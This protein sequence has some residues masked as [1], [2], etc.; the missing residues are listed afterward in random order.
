MPRLMPPTLLMC[1][2]NRRPTAATVSSAKMTRWE[3]VAEVC[4]EAKQSML[5]DLCCTYV[6]IS[7]YHSPR[8]AD[9]ASSDDET[10]PPS[11]P[12]EP[13]CANPILEAKANREPSPRGEPEP[14]RVQNGENVSSVPVVNQAQTRRG[15]GPAKCIEFEK[16]RKHGKV[17]LK[18]NNGETTLCCEN[19]SMF[20][21]RVSWIVKHY[22]NMS[23][24]RWSDVPQAHK[25]EL[26][27]RVR[28]THWSKKNDKFV[29]PTTED[30]YD[31]VGKLDTLEPEKQTDEIATGV[32]KEVLGHRPGYARGLGE[33]VIPEST[34]QRF[35]GTRERV[36]SFD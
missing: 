16:L 27:D 14:D 21:T 30:V 17:F 5:E 23:Y 19:A 7:S 24:L 9:Q 15:R 32:F 20:I 18:I 26:I 2:F 4:P 1:R 13:P 31:M 22:C 36:H 8:E 12:W 34:R 11:H 28:E 29:T 10:Q 6:D 33:M 25:D 3:T 35:I